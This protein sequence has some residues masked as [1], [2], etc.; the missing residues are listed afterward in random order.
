MQCE[1]QLQDDRQARSK[2]VQRD[3]QCNSYKPFRSQVVFQSRRKCGSIPSVIVR[4]GDLTDKICLEPIIWK[5]GGGI[6]KKLVACVR[7]L[8]LLNYRVSR[9]ALPNHSPPC[10]PERRKG[11]SFE[12][13]FAKPLVRVT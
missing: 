2:R 10:I 7:R 6:L 9:I 4:T 13:P 1:L 12:N 5:C 11:R 8:D 3:R